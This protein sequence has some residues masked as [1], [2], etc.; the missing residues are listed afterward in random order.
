MHIGVPREIKDNE[1]RVAMTPDGVEQLTGNGHT[2]TVE[3]GAGEGS[4]FPDEEYRAAGAELGD[5]AAAWDARMVV[6][7]KE[8]LEEEYGYLEERKVVFTYFHLAASR[9]LTEAVLDHGITAIAYETVG[10]GGDLPLLRPMSQVA[11]R[12]APLIGSYYLTTHNGGRGV[13]PGG[14]DGVAPGNVLVVGGG[15][16]GSNAARVAAGIGAQATVLEIDEDRI[17]ELNRELPSNVTAVK[18]TEENLADNIPA[19]DVLVGAVLVP[20]GEAPTVVE[21]RHVE[22]LPDGSVIVDVAVDQ[23]G[24]VATT[25]PTRHSDPVY[26]EQGVTHYAVTNMPGAYPRTATLGITNATLPYI[27]AIAENGWRTAMQQDETLRNGLNAVDGRLTEE[28]VA[29]T[30][31]MD[32]TDAEEFL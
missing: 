8:P 5:A 25:R 9:E 1:N 21:E 31:G 4:G 29:E 12:M 15:T 2:V 32:C 23:G 30:F 7:I 28:A 26:T 19:T 14:I 24:C 22:Q 10:D 20:G 17:Q 3:E 16:V 27:E 18:S 13:L 11:G 6:K